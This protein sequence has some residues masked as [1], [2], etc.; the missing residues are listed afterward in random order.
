VS[1]HRLIAVLLGLKIASDE[2]WM[3]AK[4]FF[5]IFLILAVLVFLGV[6]FAR[7]QESG[8]E[9]QAIQGRTPGYGV[10][11]QLR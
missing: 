5:F 8:R 7:R 6:Y 4:V 11:S 1:H 10:W 9:P 3:V 2:S